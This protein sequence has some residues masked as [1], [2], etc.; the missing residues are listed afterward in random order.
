MSH[1]TI[2]RHGFTLIELLVVI[3]IIAILASMLLP[4][5]GMIRDMAQQTKCA[6]NLRQFGLANL[7]FTTENEGM[8]LPRNFDNPAN[9][10]FFDTWWQH[11]GFMEA[12]DAQPIDYWLTPTSA[13]NVIHYRPSN[14]KAVLCPSAPQDPSYRYIWNVYGYALDSQLAGD[15]YTSGV[16]IKNWSRPIDKLRSKSAL[17]MFC[18]A[19]N[20]YVQGSVYFN[21][22]SGTADQNPTDDA[23][24]GLGWNQ[25]TPDPTPNFRGP[26]FRHRSKCS[27]SYFDGHSSAIKMGAEEFQEDPQAI[28][29]CKGFTTWAV[30]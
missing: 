22:N 2:H 29:A 5:V 16:G 24:T 30:D 15:L 27:V 25:A 13:S 17:V 28:G 19:T 18:D 26:Q 8:I 14:S 4:A 20:F 9:G 6:S 7:T 1:S 11:P 10:N 12:V 23:P 3:S 21:S